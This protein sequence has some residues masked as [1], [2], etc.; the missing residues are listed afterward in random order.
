[1]IEKT[2]EEYNKY[3]SPEATA[4]LTS[5]KEDTVTIEFTG[6][7]CYTCGFYDYFEDYQFLLEEKGVKNKIIE[8][9][10]IDNGAIVTFKIHTFVY[11][12]LH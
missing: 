9:D 6:T 10:E 3:R 4:K 1:M 5:M 8:I 7:F 11:K 2:I 12:T